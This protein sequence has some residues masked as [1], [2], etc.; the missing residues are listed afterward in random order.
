MTT[1]NT[2]GTGSGTMARLLR[3]RDQRAQELA[4]LDTTIALLNGAATETKRARASSVL[5]DALALDAERTGRR[6]PSITHTRRERSL[7]LLAQFDREQP[8]RIKSKGLAP[9][10]LHGYLK[11]KG[12]GYV[13]TAREFTVQKPR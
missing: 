4:A 10:I 13:R 1:R 9:L 3:L 7:A 12:D 5:D 6:R 11:R 2:N 8:R